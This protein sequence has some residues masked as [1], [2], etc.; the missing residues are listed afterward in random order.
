MTASTTMTEA[1]LAELFAKARAA[2]DPNL[3]AEAV[4]Y[5]RTLG[6]TVERDGDSVVGRMRFDPM[7][8]GDSSI[9]AL[10]GGTTCA[11]LESTALFAVLWT[12][13]SPQMPK[14]ITMTVDYLR[15]GRPADTVCRA[16][17]VRKGRRVLVV[18]VRAHQEREDEPI[19]TAVV[20]VLVPGEP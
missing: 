19:A 11:L 13:P 2:D 10:H 6:I 18:A 16:S 3:L 7:L 1:E 15:S 5:A 4:P 8:I 12:V 17:F 14:T 20:H 9:P